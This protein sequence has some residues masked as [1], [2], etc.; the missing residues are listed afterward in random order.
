MGC[1]FCASTLDGLVRNLNP[2]EM[3]GQIVSVNRELGPGNEIS[4][5]VVMGSGEPLENFDKMCIRDSSLPGLK[6]IKLF[7]GWI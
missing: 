7:I 4:H 3:Y 1:A 2:G 6:E 5:C